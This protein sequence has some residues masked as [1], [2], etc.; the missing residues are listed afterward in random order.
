MYFED[1]DQEITVNAPM[2]MKQ[3]IKY[4]GAITADHTCRKT[5]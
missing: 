3:N 4:G 2:D 5:Q 1:S